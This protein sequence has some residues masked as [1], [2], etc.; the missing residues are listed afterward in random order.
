MQDDLGQ[1]EKSGN[2]SLFWAECIRKSLRHDDG[3]LPLNLTRQALICL[4]YPPFWVSSGKIRK[5]EGDVT[6]SGKSG[7]QAA[8]SAQALA[9]LKSGLLPWCVDRDKR[10]RDLRQN[11]SPPTSDCRTP[12]TTA[13][14]NQ[15]GVS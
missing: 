5:H 3:A 8:R 14:T 2:L 10:D 15:A 6:P 7:K 11:H 9:I 1:K 13:L 12:V 4:R